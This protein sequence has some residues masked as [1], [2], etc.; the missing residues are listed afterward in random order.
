ML[1]SLV[2]RNCKKPILNGC[3]PKKRLIGTFK[4]AEE[5]RDAVSTGKPVV[6]LESTIITHGLPYPDNVNMARDVENLIRS[7]GV[8]PAT[9]GFVNGNGMVGIQEEH[10]EFL[11]SS[12]G[13]YK[14]SRREIPYIM[15]KKFSGGTTIAATMILAH[16]AGIDIFATGGLGG[17]H[18]GGEHTMDVSADLDE[19]SRTPVGV[20]CS[21]PKSILD[22]GRT[23]EYLE[24]K[25]VHVSTYGPDG[26]N[27]P[28]FYTSDSGFPSPYNF[29]TTEQAAEL[30][31][32]NKTFDL[33]TGA[34]FC[35]P[36]PKEFE[37]NKQEIDTIINDALTQA[38]KV[39]TK[40]K[41]VT[42]F[43]LKKIWE[44]TEG[45]S[46]HS[47]IGLMKNNATIGARIAKHMSE[48][49]GVSNKV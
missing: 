32:A 5:V 42:P 6:A 18:R 12:T 8:V 33:N 13:M 40:G 39:G 37:I 23:L 44:A 41:D 22:I 30:M 16:K 36:N 7:Q 24:T 46:L 3:N 10:L 11:G 1:K 34:V 28:G 19:L 21:G 27:V 48:I 49:T 15:S 43:L 20:V 29:Q 35:V 2:I 26:T 17:V 25:G 38:D 31:V 14:I 47:N 4:V 9:I 45:N